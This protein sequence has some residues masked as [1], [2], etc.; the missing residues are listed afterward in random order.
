MKNAIDFSKIELQ[1]GDEEIVPF[2]FENKNL[3]IEQVPCFL[4]YTNAKTH[5]IIRKN[6]VQ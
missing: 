4:T 2:S 5:E 1:A 6:S 3:K